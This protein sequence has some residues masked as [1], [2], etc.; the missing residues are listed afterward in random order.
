MKNTKRDI[1]T[2]TI[3][4]IEQL[5]VEGGE[6]RYRAKQV[7]EWLWQKASTDFDSMTS[8]PVALRS[9][10]KEQFVI[11]PVTISD[12]QVSKDGTAKVG[13]KLF[14]GHFI[15]GV[16]IPSKDR[17]TACISSQ[18]GC[19]L[20]C[21]FCATGFLERKRNLEPGEIFDQVILLNQLAVELQGSHLS[22][23]VLMGMGEPLLNYANVLFAI[24][25][26]TG[27]DGRNIGSKRITLSTAG[28]AKMIRKLADDK[29]KF[30]LALSLHAT[31]DE[32]RDKLMPINEHNNLEA[33]IEAIQYFIEH[34]GNW[35][36]FEYILLAGVND[37][38]EDAFRLIQIARKAHVKVN[39]I[40]YNPIE[41][42]SF[43]KT[44]SEQRDEFVKIL[45]QNGVTAT[46]RVSRG[47]D[48]DAAC[49][50]LANKQSK[51]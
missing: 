3:K 22:N 26:L 21:K 13:F 31:T 17:V 10:L 18:V 47:K 12:K 48:I 24:D 2:L 20:S 25:R 42:S 36:T 6:P 23:I 8:L 50:Q 15:E 33:L 35:V 28:I 11:N 27:E 51:Y 34:T 49:G 7:F 38:R 30:K 44:K 40:E 4:E 41:Q 16:L 46:V 5:L 1:R 19:S 39:I 37:T 43:V 29:V 45:E 14:D 9:K 32:A